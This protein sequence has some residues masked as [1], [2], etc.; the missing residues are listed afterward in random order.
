M[1]PQW[2]AVPRP[3]IGMLHLRPL[4]GS[5]RFAG[6]LDLVRAALLQDAEALHAGGVHAFML[7]NFGDVPF[8]P[9]DV[10]AHVVAVMTAL[11]CE[12]RAKF[13]IPLGVNV[14]RNDARAALAVALAAGAEFI[15]V[16]VLC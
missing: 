2:S 13:P 15:R 12:V 8:Y 5:P 11:A 10:P 14:L 9:A 4:P 3:L 6:N 1:L 7:E 16:N